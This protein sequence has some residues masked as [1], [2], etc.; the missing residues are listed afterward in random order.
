MLKVYLSNIATSDG[1]WLAFPMGYQERQEAMKFGAESTNE[2]GAVTSPLEG[3]KTHLEGLTLRPGQGIRELEF[4]DRHTDCMTERE[5]SIFQAALEIEEPRSVM[6]IVNL[7]CNLDKFVLYDGISNHEELGKRVLGNEEMSD[8]IS[9][10]MDYGA[11]G[12]KYAGSHAG[13]FTQLGYVV[14]TGEALEPL[15]DGKYLPNPGY[16]KSCV[17]QVW[18]S[19]PYY[20]AGNYRY[21][22]VSLPASDDRL[23]LAEEKLGWRKLDEYEVVNISC[24]VQ[25]LESCLPFSR[26]VREMNTFAGLLAER[27]ILGN[28]RTKEKLFA[29][30]EAEVPEDMKQAT[31][32]AARLEQYTILPED[33]Q[34]AGDYADY[35]LDEAQIYI[36]ERIEPFLDYERFGECQMRKDGV[37]QTEHGLVLRKDLPIAQL[38]EELEKIK[39]FSPLK[40]IL[41]PY[42]EDWGG[43]SDQPEEVSTSELCQYED[44]IL[45]RIGQERLEEEGERGLAVYLGNRLLKRKVFSMNPTVEMWN[46]ELWGVL[47]VKSH[48]PL[49]PQELSGLME[50]W[51]GQESDGWGE[52]FEQL[53]IKT[54][55]GDLCVSFWHSGDD[56]FIK[57][58]PELKQWQT[59][60][61]GMKMGGN[62]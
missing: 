52:G 57:T 43:I 56:F 21:Y 24:P 5:K 26:D 45:E 15:Y 1:L 13:C 37:V 47:E 7:S 34:D 55:E 33:I 11:A 35:F 62:G 29:A 49:S 38:T 28:D 16:D 53:E 48:G 23:A 27:N 31:A 39:L 41:Y 3:L 10:Y 25:E 58:E 6:E 32:V 36:D 9:P 50:E 14:R 44:K 40:G 30:L 51:Q 59:Q 8:K 54:E 46:G 12:E 60:D 2:I 22:P 61:F 17:I 18:L 20:A 19:S 4:L 42:D